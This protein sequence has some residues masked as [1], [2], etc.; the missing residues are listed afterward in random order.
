MCSRAALSSLPVFLT[1]DYTDTFCI[2]AHTYGFMEAMLAIGGRPYGFHR[3]PQQTR[4]RLCEWAEDV[5][6]H[7]YLAL[8]AM[9]P[10][11]YL[12]A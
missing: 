5:W 12:C 2:H 7:E 4:H 10:G 3:P 8:G 1:D 9:S 11:L 6:G